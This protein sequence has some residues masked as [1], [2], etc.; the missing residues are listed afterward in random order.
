MTR[1]KI[2]SWPLRGKHS[3]IIAKEI[4][5]PNDDSDDSLRCLVCFTMGIWKCMC[6]SMDFSHIL[7]LL[8][9]KEGAGS[10]CWARTPVV[11]SSAQWEDTAGGP[12]ASWAD[13]LS[14]RNYLVW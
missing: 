3:P 12:K 10:S 9:L 13:A 14:T 6:Q 7:V 2:T 11:Y 1:M 8:P 5:I 4:Y